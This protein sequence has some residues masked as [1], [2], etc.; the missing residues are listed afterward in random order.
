VAVEEIKVEVDSNSTNENVP[1]NLHGVSRA[2][3]IARGISASRSTTGL[4]S[5]RKFCGYVAEER[6]VLVLAQI[7]GNL[8]RRGTAG[9]GKVREEERLLKIRSNTRLICQKGAVV[10]S[11][12]KKLAEHARHSGGVVQKLEGRRGGGVEES[13]ERTGEGVG[14]AVDAEVEAKCIWLRRWLREAEYIMSDS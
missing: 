2:A 13:E 4:G 10:G 7:E 12:R 1:N 9:K 6:L 5:R 14:Q 11:G 8:Q 3:I